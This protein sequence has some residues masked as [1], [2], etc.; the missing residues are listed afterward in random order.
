MY[1]ESLDGLQG[2]YVQRVSR[3]RYIPYLKRSGEGSKCHD[4]VAMRTKNTNLVTG[5]VDLY[6]R[7]D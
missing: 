2:I 7:L 5:E 3:R 1:K 6:P 4:P